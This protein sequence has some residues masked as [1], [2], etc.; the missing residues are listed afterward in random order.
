MNGLGTPVG[1]D[2]SWNAGDVTIDVK[3]AGVAASL[4]HRALAAVGH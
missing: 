2:I 4:T 1:D 3:V